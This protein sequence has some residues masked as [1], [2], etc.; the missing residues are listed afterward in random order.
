MR[1]KEQYQI[2]G[3]NGASLDTCKPLTHFQRILHRAVE[4]GIGSPILVDT[5]HDCP[6]LHVV[7]LLCYTPVN[8]TNGPSVIRREAPS[9]GALPSAFIAASPV[10]SGSM[11]V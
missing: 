4:A 6:V 8:F 1:A 9:A 10:P 7:D 2:S 5:D 3:R 11:A